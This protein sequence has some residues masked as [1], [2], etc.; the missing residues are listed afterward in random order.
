M[1][2][3]VARGVPRCLGFPVYVMAK[4]DV[5]RSLFVDR[6]QQRVEHGEGVVDDDHDFEG[7]HD[8]DDRMEGRRAGNVREAEVDRCVRALERRLAV[9]RRAGSRER[10]LEHDDDR[11]RRAHARRPRR[12]LSRTDVD[13]GHRAVRRVRQRY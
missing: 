9:L 8:C 10:V 1:S 2:P 11:R 12:A 13:I 4:V 3:A 5:D 6:V 7:R